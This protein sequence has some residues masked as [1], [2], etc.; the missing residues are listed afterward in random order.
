MVFETFVFNYTAVHLRRAITN[1][2]N[3]KKNKPVIPLI[4]NKGLCLHMEFPI[5]GEG[6]APVYLK[7]VGLK[8]GLST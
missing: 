2:W 1:N 3:K 8:L 5:W 4:S 7:S 6:E